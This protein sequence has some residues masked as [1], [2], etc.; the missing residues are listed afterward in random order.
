MAVKFRWGPRPPS[1][2]APAPSPEP[3]P[4]WYPIKAT[5]IDGAPFWVSVPQPDM[6]S[7]VGPVEH[8]HCGAGANVTPTA[9][10][11][12]SVLSRLSAAE[13]SLG[14]K[15]KVSSTDYSSYSGKYRSVVWRLSGYP[16]AINFSIPAMQVKSDARPLRIEFN[17]SKLGAEGVCDLLDLVHAATHGMLHVGAYLHDTH[18]TRIDVAVDIVGLSVC[19]LIIT[20]KSE[21]KRVHYYGSDGSL[22]SVY[23][24]KKILAKKSDQAKPSSRKLGV[25]IAR[26]YD[27][28]RELIANG[29]APDFGACDVT[30]VEISKSRF[31]NTKQALIGLPSLKNPLMKVHVGQATSAA[32]SDHQWKWLEYLELRRGGGASRAR[33]LM[34]LTAQEAEEFE[35][36]YRQHPRDV[37]HSNDVWAH[38][39]SGLERTGTDILIGAAKAK[40]HNATF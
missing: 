34:A 3:P 40:S 14:G 26:I 19:E 7:L 23:L 22:E 35:K 17:P 39:Q 30:R 21:D 5:D 31:G 13:A 28:R 20:G 27:R 9:E 8:Q 36:A 16:T 38:W 33:D 18:V 37:I 25:L 11:A 24:H 10:L 32:P 15:V 1:N 29:A 12:Q 6:I 4:L 2:K